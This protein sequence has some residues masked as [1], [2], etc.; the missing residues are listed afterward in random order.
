MA[1]HRTTRTRLLPAAICAAIPGIALIAGAGTA[2][3]DDTAPV[4]CHE[5]AVCAPV[6]ADV[7]DLLVPVN[8]PVDVNILDHALHH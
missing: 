3:A 7:H 6:N 8:V 5:N 2:A 4:T 1:R